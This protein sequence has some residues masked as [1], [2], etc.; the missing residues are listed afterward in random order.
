M[1]QENPQ[2]SRFDHH[3]E[4][5]RV[6]PHG[7]APGAARPGAGAVRGFT[8]IEL[9]TVIA[10][11][12]I[13][14]SILV[15]VVSSVRETARRSV[16][17]SNLRQI[18][19]ALHLY[20]SDNDERLPRKEEPG[21]WPWDMDA[22]LM[23]D[24][25]EIA[26]VERGIFYCPSGAPNI[27]DERWSTFAQVGADGRASGGFRVTSYVLMIPG[28]ANLPDR[29]VNRRVQAD[30]THLRTRDLVAEPDLGST[31]TNRPLAVD[32]VFE[33]GGNFADIDQGGIE[34]RTN[35]LDGTHPAGGN[36]LFL[37]GHVQ[38]R[39]FSEMGRG[40]GTQARF[41]SGGES[42]WW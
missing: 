25:I 28:T 17:S 23:D 1:K 35:H 26:G 10:I 4:R 24:L 39:S 21:N 20:A 41:Q 9:L 38:W 27:G 2:L 8:L 33:R 40:D 11:I 7:T 3:S 32:A 16:C 42:W 6:S 37:D 13:L 19:L 14:A 34:N 5:E 22:V 12:G 30:I 29:Y 15:P 36:I 18:G 31:S